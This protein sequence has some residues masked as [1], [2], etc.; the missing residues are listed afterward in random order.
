MKLILSRLLW[1]AL[2]PSNACYMGNMAPS[3]TR[4]RQGQG[5]SGGC[6]LRA[7]LVA[8]PGHLYLSFL[9][10]KFPR[11]LGA[12]TDLAAQ[13]STVPSTHLL[14]AVVPELVGVRDS[15]GLLLCKK[16]HH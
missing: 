12:A 3:R 8:L 13:L 14:R 15:N 11:V 10:C 16:G 5:Y 1:T 7:R 2:Y 9:H 4:A 6:K